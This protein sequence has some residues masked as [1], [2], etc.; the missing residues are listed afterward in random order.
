MAYEKANSDDNSKPQADA[1]KADIRRLRAAVASSYKKMEAFRQNRRDAIK[2]LVGTHYNEEKTFDKVPVNLLALAVIIY[3]RQLVSRNPKAM[4]STEFD[5]LRSRA[6]SL[7]LAGNHLFEEIK[8]KDT[9]K[10]AALNALVGMGIVK[11]GLTYGKTVEIDGTT[12]DVGQP[13][14]DAI[15]LDDFVFD[16]TAR[17]W[18]QVQFIGNKYRLPLS[19]VKK[20]ERY[21]AKVR[22]KL[23]PSCGHDDE[24]ASDDTDAKSREISRGKDGEDDYAEDF[25]DLWDIYQPRLNKLC[26]YAAEQPELDALEEIDWEGPEASPCGPYRPIGFREVPG[27][28]LPLPPVA[29]WRDL[30]ELINRIFNKIGRQ[31]ERQKT[32]SCANDESA[33]ILITKANDG[34]CVNVNPDKVKEVRYGGPEQVSMAFA[35]YLRDLF[36]YN[37][38]GLDIAGGLGPMSSTVGQDK[39]LDENAS[40]TLAD[41]QDTFSDFTEAIIQDLMWYLFYH[42][43]IKIPLVKTIG[44]LEIPTEFNSDER[45]GDY[46]QYNFKIHAYSMQEETPQSKLEAFKVL[47][48][49]FVIPLMPVMQQSGQVPNVEGILR[50]LAKLMDIEELN[51][52]FQ[53]Q[54]PSQ[55]PPAEPVQ[56]PDAPKMPAHTTRTYER[57][58]RSALTR[59]GQDTLMGQA[60]LGAGIQPNSANQIGGGVG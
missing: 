22:A 31:A 3:T 42:P 41:M 4:V 10:T 17:R 24:I 12:H 49:E 60:F 27:Q 54:Q 7:A 37:A 11:M 48:Q 26:T 9:L 23:K 8:L 56:T 21:D 43:M 46:L 19:E 47:F 40:K 33:A 13:F 57:V 34:D 5:E 53:F 44:G 32:I 6:E 52:L 29:L 28:I 18:D 36:A 20:S 45:E 14:C 51:Q 38:G 16:M 58:S 35:T 25:I 39:L 50:Y 59:P 1:P 55:F 2:Q 30:H 15:D